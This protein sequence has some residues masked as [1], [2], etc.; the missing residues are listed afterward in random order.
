MV[1]D[2]ELTRS[3]LSSPVR[4]PRGQNRAVTTKVAQ[5][6]HRTHVRLLGLGVTEIDRGEP[7]AGVEGFQKSKRRPDLDVGVTS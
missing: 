4:L 1:K 6:A 5:I 7:R 3:R 2:V